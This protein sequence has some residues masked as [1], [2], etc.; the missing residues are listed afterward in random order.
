MELVTNEWARIF[1][2]ALISIIA[3]SSI[4]VSWAL[5]R[6][7]HSSAYL[8]KEAALMRE[9]LKGID[10]RLTA[11]AKSLISIEGRL[12]REE[13]QIGRSDPIPESRSRPRRQSAPS[14]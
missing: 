14:P 13:V 9:E 12:E 8:L 10:S 2:Y 1:L 5:L 6:F 11:I 7:S 3:L 4:I